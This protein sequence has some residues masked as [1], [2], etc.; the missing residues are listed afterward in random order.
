MRVSRQLLQ[1][2]VESIYGCSLR[3]W[4]PGN[5]RGSRSAVVPAGGGSSSFASRL[6]QALA[7][8]AAYPA[9]RAKSLSCLCAL[10]LG[11][12]NPQ[13]R[14]NAG[15]AESKSFARNGWRFAMLIVIPAL[16]TY[17]PHP[18]AQRPKNLVRLEF[19]PRSARHF[20][21]S[22]VQLLT[23]VSGDELS[24]GS[25]LTSKRPSEATSY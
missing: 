7:E 3:S 22:A 12:E 9:C 18:R 5:I 10:A 15:N 4:V 25:E 24:A 23:R 1:T 21:N 13:G 16:T 11:P 2:F 6:A 19:A 8:S 17:L 20:F 14:P